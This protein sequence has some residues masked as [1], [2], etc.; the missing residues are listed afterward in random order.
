M[1]FQGESLPIRR[2]VRMLLTPEGA[3]VLAK[4][5]DGLPVFFE[6]SYGRGRFCLL[7][8]P[9]ERQVAQ[10]PHAT[11]LGYWKIYAELA[12]DIRA[13]APV[14]SAS[15]QLTVTVHPVDSDTAFIAL[16]NNGEE[17]VPWPIV[18]WNIETIWPTHTSSESLRPGEWRVLACRRIV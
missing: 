11:E 8:L 10:I 9:R 6:Q 5:H 16:Q 3:K 4:D 18:R 2:Q 17:D 7:T 14:D 13:A 1:C 12:R 15:P